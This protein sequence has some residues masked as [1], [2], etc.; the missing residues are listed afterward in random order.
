M[1]RTRR[2]PWSRSEL[3]KPGAVRTYTGRQ[4][5]MIAFPL[6]GIGAGCV[7]LGGWGQLRD[8]E[9][10]GRPGKGN[11]N[12]M[13]FFTLYA[14]P[15]GGE[16]VTKVLQGPAGGPRMGPPGLGGGGG[17]WGRAQGAGLPH[18]R[19]CEFTA[20]YPFATVSLGDTTMPLRASLTAW[21]PLIPLDDRDSSIPCAIF[22]WTIT[23]PTRR[24]VDATLFVNLSNTIGFPDCGKGL[25]RFREADGIRG[26]ELRTRKHR[27]ASPRY[28]TMA[29]ATPHRKVTY[30]NHWLRGGWFDTLTDFWT[31]VQT[32][33]LDE[34][35]AP[36]VSPDKAA[37]AGTIGLTFSLKAGASRTLPVVLAWHFPTTEMYSGPKGEDGG[38]PTWKNYCATQW[39]DA[40]DVAGYVVGNLKRLESQTRLY[41]ETLR[42]TTMPGQVVEAVSATSAVLKS[43]TCLRLTG[44]EFWAWEGCGDSFGCCTGTCTHVWNYQQMLPYLFPALERSIRETDYANNLHEDGSLTFRMPLPLGTPGEPGSHG[45]ADGQLGGIMKVYRE[46]RVSGD[47]EWL[48]RI[49]PGV[50]RALE[51]AWVRWDRDRDGVMEGVQHNT[52]DIEFWGPNTMLGS[53]YLGALRAG[54]EMARK[55]GDEE[56]AG[57]YRRLFETGKAWSGENLWN[58]EHFV[59]RVNLG[60]DGRAHERPRYQYGAGCLSDQLL[61]QLFA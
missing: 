17:Q 53:F 41:D 34:S 7:S 33:A 44:G 49:W 54:E 32:G 20:S 39:K 15:K 55:I 6:G 22:Q 19:Q 51:Y 61:G 4:L 30:L 48:E 42:A 58:G 18:F 37:E 27:R 11:L 5:D 9:I 40:W 45:A 3:R 31:Q 59:Q 36:S 12:E 47:D 2:L 50:K 25:N 29:L 21:N 52:Y 26:L 16:P 23:N 38:Q 8:W 13:A 28:G 56:A 14:R 46:W 35:V 24:A 1:A 43:T 10:Y 60:Q 57:T